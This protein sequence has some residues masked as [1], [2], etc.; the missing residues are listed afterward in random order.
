ML[1]KRNTDILKIIF[2]TSLF[3]LSYS[4]SATLFCFSMW[5]FSLYL[6]VIVK[7]RFAVVTFPNIGV[8]FF[9]LIELSCHHSK[10]LISNYWTWDPTK[11]RL[12]LVEEYLENNKK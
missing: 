4:L 11:R 3:Q 2:E 7:N 9:I 6:E 1:Q 10:K 5:N 8:F 12:R